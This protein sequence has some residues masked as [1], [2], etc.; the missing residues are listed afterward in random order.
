MFLTEDRERL[1]EIYDRLLQLY[2]QRRD[3]TDNGDLRKLQAVNKE[4]APLEAERQSIRRW[5]T[6][7][8]A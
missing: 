2:V 7:G 3:A 1:T 5:D 6:V 4:I 8:A